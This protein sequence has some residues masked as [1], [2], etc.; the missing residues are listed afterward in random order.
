MTGEKLLD[1]Q[2]AKILTPLGVEVESVSVPENTL[3]L[4]R[5]LTDSFYDHWGKIIA[6]TTVAGAGYT[7]YI[8]FNA[9]GKIDNSWPDFVI[10]G[11]VLASSIVGGAAIG[12]LGGSMGGLGIILMS[13]QIEKLENMIRRR[14]S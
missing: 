3:N 1:R 2:L 12:Y 4:T 9:M 10:K 13:Y 7:S 14:F 8:T 11:V 5:R 6:A